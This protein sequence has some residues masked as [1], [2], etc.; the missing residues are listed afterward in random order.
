[1]GDTYSRAGNAVDPPSL[2]PD[3][4]STVLRAPSRPLVLIPQTLSEITGPV[5][6]HSDVTPAEADL[7]TQ[8]AGEPQGG[9]FQVNTYTKNDQVYP[10]VA[11][12]DGGS[13]VVVWESD[14]QDGSG[15]GAFG[16]RFDAAG[17]RQGGEF[18]INVYTTNEQFNPIVAVY[19]PEKFIVVWSSFGQDGST[20]GAYGRR[21]PGTGWAARLD[22]FDALRFNR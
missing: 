6:G 15:K 18:Q 1:M 11:I 3:Y 17:N 2:S 4:R 5:Y 21:Y 19:A 22:V 10:T 12:E 7:T 20:E 13:F 14:G 9:E 8:H 16:Q